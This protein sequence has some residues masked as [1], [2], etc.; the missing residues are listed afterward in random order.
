MSRK[1][2]TAKQ[3]VKIVEAHKDGWTIHQ[4]CQKYGKSFYTIKDIVENIPTGNDN[5]QKIALAN[6]ALVKA[7]KPDVLTQALQQMH[8]GLA[9]AIP[10]AR[11]VVIDME[12]GEAAVE[13]LTTLRVKVKP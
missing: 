11:R 8:K 13:L 5:A 4:L 7:N 9:E 6:K 10:N 1:A 2:L 12:S 3:K